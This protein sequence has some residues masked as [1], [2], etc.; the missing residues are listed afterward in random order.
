MTEEKKIFDLLERDG[1]NCSVDSRGAVTVNL[2]T[3]PKYKNIDELCT[4]VRKIEQTSVLSL[5]DYN[6]NFSSKGLKALAGLPNLRQISLPN[7]VALRGSDYRVLT[8]FPKLQTL[9][10]SPI[11][12]ADEAMSYIGQLEELTTLGISGQF[13]SDTGLAALKNLHQL[14]D[15]RFVRSTASKSF[16]VLSEMKELTHLSIRETGADDSALEIIGHLP[17]INEL[18]VAYTLVTNEGFEFLGDL[19]NLYLLTLSG[20]KITEKGVKQ[21]ITGAVVSPLSHL[22]GLRYLEI[23]DIVFN[24]TDVYLL[25]QFIDLSGIRFTNCF[26]SNQNMLMLQSELP[27]CEI[28]YY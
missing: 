22:Q 3:V 19:K 1:V 24:D 4:L 18:D 5:S 14:Y 6:H 27:A 15:L 13:V 12:E 26:I 25:S 8:S 21:I 9:Y 11:N 28:D 7:S 16:H 2:S 20:Q 17:E 23:G 10:A